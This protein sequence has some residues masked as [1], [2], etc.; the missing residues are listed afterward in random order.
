MAVLASGRGS[1]LKS[2][3]EAM[4]DPAWPAEVALVLSDVQKAPAL[5]VAREA[6]I[7]AI[8][9]DP[10]RKGPRLSSNAETTILAAL[11]ERAIRCLVLAG[12][13][14]ILSRSFLRSFEGPVLNI[15]PSLLPAFPGLD[16]QGQAFRHGVRVAGATVHLVDEGIDTGPIV[17]QSAVTVHA[18]D[19]RDALANR[20]LEAEHRLYPEAIRKVLTVPYVVEGRR[21]RFHEEETSRS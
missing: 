3:L 11:A 14:R 5:G 17:A 4:K 6:G 13:M 9:I 19:D 15:H 20:I 1:N 21:L 7:E 18:N 16:A 2:I 12:F 10:D 8:A